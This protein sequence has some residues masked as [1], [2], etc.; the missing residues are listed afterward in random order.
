VEHRLNLKDTR[1]ERKDPEH[2]E[3]SDA[4]LYEEGEF[5]LKPSEGLHY[6]SISKKWYDLS[7]TY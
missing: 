6:K 2:S 5:T 1:S 4:S 3:F 7:V